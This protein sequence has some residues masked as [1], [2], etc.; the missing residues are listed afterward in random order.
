M[1]HV[2]V[3]R[4]ISTSNNVIEYEYSVVNCGGDSFKVLGI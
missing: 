2:S 4:W 3:M 1:M